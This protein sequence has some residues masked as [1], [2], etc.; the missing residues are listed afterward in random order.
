MVH[1]SVVLL[2][3]VASCGEP[4]LLLF[5]A[6]SPSLPWEWRCRLMQSPLMLPSLPLLLPPFLLLMLPMLGPS[7]AWSGE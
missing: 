1:P 6:L 3:V 7:L 2:D 4:L 5:F